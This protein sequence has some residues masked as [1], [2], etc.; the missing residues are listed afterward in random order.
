MVIMNKIT[1]LILLSTVSLINAQEFS[2]GVKGGVNLSSYYETNTNDLSQRTLY[3]VGLV[4]DV[5]LSDKFSFAPELLFSAEGFEVKDSDFS[6]DLNYLRVPLLMKY[7]V[8]DSFSLNIGPQFGALIKAKNSEGDN[9]ENTK[10][11]DFGF[12]FGST[13][14]LGSGLIVDTS[15]NYGLT[16][17]VDD[18]Q[19]RQSMLQFSLGYILN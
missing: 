15:W 17:I 6:V 4:T 19:I 9:L 14:T 8:T 2:I 5:I 1:L 3:H 12:K 11:L 18:L 7:Y 10:S 16:S 13:Y